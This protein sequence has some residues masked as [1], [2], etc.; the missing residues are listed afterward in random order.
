MNLEELRLYCLSLP[1]VTEDFPF[2]ES[3]LVFRVGGK[4]F[5]LTNID[6]RPLTVNLKCEPERALELRASYACVQPGWHMNK[7]H[8]NTVTCDGSVG[9]NTLLEWV[10]H[11][12]DRVVAT[13]PAAQR[14]KLK[15]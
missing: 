8:W 6:S 7:K 4:I 13:L 9:R 3:V 1:D 11:S 5:A 12:W 15:R 2:D 14:A 10:D